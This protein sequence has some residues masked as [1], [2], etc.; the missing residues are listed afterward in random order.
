MGFER[1]TVLPESLGR[2]LYPRN[3]EE[4]GALA[5]GA[6]S[7]AALIAYVIRGRRPSSAEIER[8]RR[9]ELSQMGRIIDGVI[10]DTPL[11]RHDDAEVPT[12]I[13]YR[14]RIAGVVYE[15]SQ[16]VGSLQPEV[17]HFRIDLPVSIKYDPRNPA[18]SIIVSETW[19]GLRDGTEPTWRPHPSHTAP[20]SHP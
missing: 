6:I 18:N 1:G 4:F 13:G 12:L 10:V 15:C 2:L 17:E 3:R 19:S 9:E 5:A 14:Y 11:Y 8:R 20:S 16:D 7:A